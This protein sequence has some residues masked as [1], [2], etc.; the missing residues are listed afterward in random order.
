VRARLD[1]LTE[2]A[3]EWARRGRRWSRLNRRAKAEVDG[4]DAPSANDEYLLYQ[5]V[6]G[7]W[8]MEILGED[9]PNHEALAAFAAR[10]GAYAIKAAREAKLRTSWTTPG[11]AY[12]DAL[13]AF[14][15]RILDPGRGAPFLTDARSFAH[16]VAL[17][18]A[19]NGLSQALLKLTVPGV[20]DIYQGC[21]LW[22]LSLVDPDNRRPVDYAARR[23]ALEGLR[24]V[25]PRRL[26]ES[27]TDGRIKLHVVSRILDLRRRE[28]ALFRNGAYLPLAVEGADADR[29][30]A[31]ARLADAAAC[32]VVA[33]RFFAGLIAEGGAIPLG[34]S[35]G[36]ASIALAN[37]LAGRSW[38]NVLTGERLQG[39]GAA[40]PAARA[41]AELPLAA[42][43]SAAAG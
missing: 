27:W 26:L 15:Q 11:Q 18:G 29:I 36:D 12:E 38:R 7:A 31:F 21:E 37:E 40:L 6:I 30:C 32:V 23:A 22:D 19:L 14:V 24:A 16:A 8:P 34:A 35:W 2:V 43:V 3:D 4:A 10:I 5:T 42:L 41:L 9:E 17:P 28:P 20:P 39:M 1:V 25:A 13:A 33:P